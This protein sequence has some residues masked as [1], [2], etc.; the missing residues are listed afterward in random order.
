MGARARKNFMSLDEAHGL[1]EAQRKELRE[2]IAG[3]KKFR[4]YGSILDREE[5]KKINAKIVAQPQQFLFT[6]EHG[7]GPKKLSL[8]ALGGTMIGFT[9]TSPRVFASYEYVPHV[10]EEEDRVKANDVLRRKRRMTTREDFC[11]TEH[12]SIHEVAED[13]GYDREFDDLYLTCNPSDLDKQMMVLTLKD[14]PD[15]LEEIYRRVRREK[16]PKAMRNFQLALGKAIEEVGHQVFILENSADLIDE[17]E[18]DLEP[19]KTLSINFLAS[20]VL[21]AL[22]FPRNTIRERRCALMARMAGI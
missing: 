3:N 15:R 6:G 19:S 1:E 13:Y 17:L 21:A 9:K 5:S 16:S 11:S 4:P 8:R 22:G 7:L 18:E 20:T 2:R 14:H 10:R 12:T